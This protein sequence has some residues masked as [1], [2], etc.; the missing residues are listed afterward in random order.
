MVGLVPFERMRK[1]GKSNPSTKNF[2][3]TMQGLMSIAK[4]FQ[5]IWNDWTDSSSLIMGNYSNDFAISWIFSNIL[6]KDFPINFYF[7]VRKMHSMNEPWDN[8]NSKDIL[9]FTELM[10]PIHLRNNNETQ[11]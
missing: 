4:M 6:T 11:Q 2:A 8:E 10:K 9:N 5:W 1:E 3:L 7:F